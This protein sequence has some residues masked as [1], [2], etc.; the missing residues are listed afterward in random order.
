MTSVLFAIL[1]LFPGTQ[2]PFYGGGIGVSQYGDSINDLY[3]LVYVEAYAG[4]FVS[5]AI[6]IDF[7]IQYDTNEMKHYD[8]INFNNVILFTRASYQK[9]INK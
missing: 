5:P 1:S 7:N 9:P 8:N 3:N 2:Y 6:K 4:A